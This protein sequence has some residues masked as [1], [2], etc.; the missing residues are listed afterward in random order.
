[1]DSMGIFLTSAR[2]GGEGVKSFFEKRDPKF[3]DTVT[4]PTIQG[5]IRAVKAR[6]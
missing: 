2:D 4:H 3:Q 6:L 5:Y 1:L